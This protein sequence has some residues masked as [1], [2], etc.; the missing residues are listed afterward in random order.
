[1]WDTLRGPHEADVEEGP[2]DQFLL[3]SLRKRLPYSSF[4]PV[5][6]GISLSLS[7]SH[8]NR[9]KVKM[10]KAQQTWWVTRLLFQQLNVV[11]SNKARSLTEAM[12]GICL[13]NIEA[14]S[15]AAALC[16]RQPG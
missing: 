16:Q 4:S 8:T 11:H 13:R 2:A 12:E 7:L 3:L 9:P 6:I 10:L 15:V 5:K 1:M 14:H